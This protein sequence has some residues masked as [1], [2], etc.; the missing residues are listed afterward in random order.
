MHRREFFK[1]MG[2]GIG[3]GLFFLPELL[4]GEEKGLIKNIPA[5]R[6]VQIHDPDA[7]YW[8]FA[9]G[10]YG[11]YVNQGLVD[12]MVDRGV[13]ELTGLLD[14]VSAWQRI[15]SSY[16][17]GD[18]V[19]IKVNFNNCR[20]YNDSDNEIDSVIEPINSIISGLISIGIPAEDIW[21]YDASRRLPN[22]FKL[23][24]LFHRFFKKELC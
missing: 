5:C 18:K 13:C 16:Q 19:A 4:K 11:D 14:P 2:L 7:T 24:N 21:V 22:Y 8:D 6:V 23:W 20:D 1:N 15:M 9:T 3:T 17:T 12:A 10:Y